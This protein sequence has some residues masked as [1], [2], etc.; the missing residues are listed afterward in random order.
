MQLSKKYTDL[1]VIKDINLL[2]DSKIII[3]GTG[4]SGKH[5]YKEMIRLGV[6]VYCFC[7]TQPHNK[8]LYGLPVISQEEL[9]VIVQREE[10][11]IVVASV[12]FN[13]IYD[14]LIYKGIEGKGIISNFTVAYSVYLNIN[15]K[16]IPK[17]YRADYKKIVNVWK[18]IQMRYVESLKLSDDFRILSS[19]VMFP[20]ILIFQPDKV[21]SMSIHSILKKYGIL[22]YHCHMLNNRIMN[23]DKEYQEFCIFLKIGK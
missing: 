18:K 2:L 5:F 7:E 11:L 22:S 12:Y 19:A 15:E 4:K 9:A 14:D 6:N 1:M 21:G 23:K 3:Y 17:D 16:K 13:E 8:E 20:E 10:I